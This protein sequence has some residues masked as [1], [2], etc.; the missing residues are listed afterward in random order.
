M[1]KRDAVPHIGIMFNEDPNHHIGETWATRK[2]YNKGFRFSEESEREFVRQ[3]EGSQLTDFLINVNFMRSV[4]PSEVFDSYTTSGLTFNESGLPVDEN[5]NVLEETEN[6]YYETFVR[7]NFDIFDC[8]IRNFREIGVRPWL[9]FRMN[10][11]HG[12]AENETGMLTKFWQEHP[13][14]Y[15]IHHHVPDGY[16]ARTFDYEQQIVRDRMYAYIKDVLFRSRKRVP[17]P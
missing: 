16:F 1:K 12:V 5:G 7:D 9:S 17:L 10:D 11:V 15:R 14:T 6:A 8:W 3:Y 13:E 4:Y 2:T